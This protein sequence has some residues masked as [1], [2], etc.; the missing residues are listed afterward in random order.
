[1]KLIIAG[2]RSFA[3]YRFLRDTLDRLTAKIDG[4]RLVILSGH[5]K[6][7]D[8]LGELWAYERRITYEVH[9]ADWKKHGKAAGPK[10]NAAML[11]DADAVIAFWDGKSPGTRD[12]LKQAEKAG[13]KVKVV[14]V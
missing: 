14:E 7:A 2:S 1:M 8:R 3:D 9:R 10:R 13:I 12:L 6:G 11:K 5:A 4:R